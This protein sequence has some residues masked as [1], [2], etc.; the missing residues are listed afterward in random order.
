[1]GTLFLDLH[2]S[3]VAISSSKNLIPLPKCVMLNRV[4]VINLNLTAYSFVI[5][6]KYVSYD[7]M[8]PK[9]V[10]WKSLELS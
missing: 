8:L 2:F 10:G 3:D 4:R 6:V 7:Y 9:M 5:S 1:M